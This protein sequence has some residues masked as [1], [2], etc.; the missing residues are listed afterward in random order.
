MNALFAE[1]DLPMLPR[2]GVRTVLMRRSDVIVL[3][4]L[5]HR[6]GLSAKLLRRVCK[7]FGIARQ[8]RPN[9]PLEI[10]WPGWL[11]LQHGDH[12][13]LEILREGF[14]DHPLLARYFREAGVPA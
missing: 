6:T 3:K 13:A 11:M 14:R 9:S 1:A 2:K 7:E 4:E 8:L 10:S 12:E 5:V